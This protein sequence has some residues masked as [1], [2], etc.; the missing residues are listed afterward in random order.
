MT[1]QEYLKAHPPT[2]N[3]SP[4]PFYS[5]MGDFLTL[6][7]KNDQAYAETLVDGVT[8]YISME[9]KEMVGVKIHGV[10]KLTSKAGA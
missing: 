1:L 8:A 5:K 3:F 4:T 10:S 2:G 7:W 9:T 6:F